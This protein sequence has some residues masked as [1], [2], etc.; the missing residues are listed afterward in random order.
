MKNIPSFIIKDLCRLNWVCGPDLKKMR[1]DLF[2]I[3]AFNPLFLTPGASTLFFNNNQKEHLI[4][5]LNQTDMAR[6]I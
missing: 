1:L 5:A 4:E 3:Y 6:G 2:Y